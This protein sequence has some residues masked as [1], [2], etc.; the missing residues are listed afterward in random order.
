M[1]TKTVFPTNEIEYPNDNTPVSEQLEALK[2]T[3][4]FVKA[5]ISL[6]EQTRDLPKCIFG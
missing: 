3:L 6:Q 2:E 5:V 4:T 1:R